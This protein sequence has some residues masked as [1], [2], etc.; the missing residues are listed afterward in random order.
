MIKAGHKKWARLLFDFYIKRELKKHFSHFY[1]VNNY[2]QVNKESPLVITP[3]HISWWDGFFIDYI[4]NKEVGR[5]IYV[6]MLEEQLRKYKFFRK[7]GAYSVNL[8]N[9]FS[10]KD[11]ILY[12]REIVSDPANVTVIYPQGEI[13]P[14]EKRPM[15]LKE[16]I[17]LFVKGNQGNVIVLPVGFKIQ[18]YNE[19]KP[20]V[21]IRFGE[22]LKSETVINDFKVYE[23]KFTENLDLLN[24]AAINKNFICDIWE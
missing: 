20:A 14:F 9:G 18:Y 2:P 11:T 17:K 12:T 4:C 13:E 5:R 6:M 16:G 23:N 8:G 3:N 7:L 10:V 15:V 24:N 22:P 21:I 1:L 19:K